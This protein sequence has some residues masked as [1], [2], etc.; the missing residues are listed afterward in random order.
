M[1]FK[2]QALLTLREFIPRLCGGSVLLI[3]FLLCCVLGFCVLCVV[4]PM[5][6]V[7]L[8]CTFW[9][10]LRFSLTFFVSYKHW[11]HNLLLCCPCSCRHLGE[12]Y[13]RFFS[14]SIITRER[15]EEGLGNLLAQLN[16]NCTN[17]RI[18]HGS[19]SI[20]WDYVKTKGT[21]S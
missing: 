4:C 19:L 16:M 10:A 12:K 14:H 9:I 7:F 15:V 2:R 13:K 20:T 8:D 21:R 6:R 11:L 5:L 1:C 18:V 17:H 3:F